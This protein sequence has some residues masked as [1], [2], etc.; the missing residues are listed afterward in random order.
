MTNELR[1]TEVLEAPLARVFSAWCDAAQMQRWF[2]ST[3]MTVPEA[4]IDLRPG[5]RWRIVLRKHDGTL[6]AVGGEYREITPNER[7]RFSWQWEGSPVLTEVELGFRALDEARTELQLLH[8]EFPAP[9]MRD[10]HVHGWRPCL[11]RLHVYLE[12]PGTQEPT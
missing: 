8:R 10:L 5:G 2:G 6:M 1:I 7:L 11:A 4:S 12:R 3:D 9:E